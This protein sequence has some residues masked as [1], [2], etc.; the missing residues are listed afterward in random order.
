MPPSKR[1]SKAVAKADRCF[2]KAVIAINQHDE[3]IRVAAFVAPFGTDYVL[4]Q[5]EDPFQSQAA[6][7]LSQVCRG[8]RYRKSHQLLFLTG[9]A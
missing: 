2:Q 1:V 5:V 4:P 9:L 7:N 6:Q 8:C 3:T